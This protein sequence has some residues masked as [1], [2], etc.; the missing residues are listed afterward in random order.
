MQKQ[1]VYQETILAEDSISLNKRTRW[2]RAKF[3]YLNFFFGSQKKKTR[4]KKRRRTKGE[5]NERE[6]QTFEVSDRRSAEA[7][8]AWR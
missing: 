6:K 7:G 3:E 4:R 1:I 8:H 2:S 5:K